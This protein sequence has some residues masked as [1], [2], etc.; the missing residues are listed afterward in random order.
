RP[1]PGA[2]SCEPGHRQGGR[3]CGRALPLR[4]QRTRGDRDPRRTERSRQRRRLADDEQL[5][6]VEAVTAV[7]EACELYRFYHAGDE[8]TLAL[9]GVSLEVRAGELVAV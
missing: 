5:A 4:P 2:W 6:A 9:R 8:E 3:G 7:L 1:L